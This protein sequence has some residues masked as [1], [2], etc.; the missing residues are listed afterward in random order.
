M[1]RRSAAI[2]S[3]GVSSRGHPG[4]W[5]GGEPWFGRRDVD[6]FP[7]RFYFPSYPFPWEGVYRYQG[8]TCLFFLHVGLDR[9][10]SLPPRIHPQSFGFTLPRERK[11]SI[12]SDRSVRRW[13]PPSILLSHPTLWD[14]HRPFHTFRRLNRPRAPQDACDLRLPIGE[15]QDERRKNNKRK[16][17]D[18]KKERR[19]KT[20]MRAK[21]KRR[22]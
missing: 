8:S 16:E 5:Q 15:E 3:G 4:R 22:R 12:R 21:K 19:K 9:C 10:A 1:W 18:E 17:E 20:N 14:E 2:W 11:E 13:Y 6:P 7:P